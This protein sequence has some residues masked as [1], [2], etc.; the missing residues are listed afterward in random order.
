MSKKKI[1]ESRLYE[2][3]KKEKIAFTEI[4]LGGYLKFI[5]ASLI[6]L[7]PIIIKTYGIFS[8]K[9][10]ICMLMLLVTCIVKKLLKNSYYGYISGLFLIWCFDIKNLELAFWKFPSYSGLLIATTVHI[11]CHVHME[12]IFNTV[13]GYCTIIIHLT[14]WYLGSYYSGFVN[15]QMPNELI[16]TMVFFAVANF[17]WYKYKLWKD[18]QDI[19][20]KIHL[21]ENQSNILNLINA[22]PEGIVVVSENCEVIMKNCTYDKLLQGNILEEMK[23]IEKFCSDQKRFDEDLRKKICEFFG[24]DKDSTKFG[25]LMANRN[26]LEC[27]GSKVVWDNENAIVLTFREITDLVKLENQITQT[28]KTLKILRGISHEL[29][30]PMNMVINQN[31]EI[32]NDTKGAP[33]IVV[34]TVKRNVSILQYILSL[35]RDMIDYSHLKSN[36]LALSFSWV[37]ISDLIEDSITILQDMYINSLFELHLSNQNMNVYTD[38]NR[39]RQSLL[40][41][42]STSLG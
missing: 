38:K 8:Y 25:V 9:M 35:I 13:H 19:E 30:T 28:S 2:R 14:I 21:E 40:S 37:G 36:N 27:T 10:L 41:L 29:K 32:L 34:K 3:Y 15:S 7:I 24:T 11:F 17:F 22:V 16:F 33:D 31:L 39:L 1:E 23:L 4:F 6:I 12:L 20:R 26:Y 42:I 18:Y 5:L